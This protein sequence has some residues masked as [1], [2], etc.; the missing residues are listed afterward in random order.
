[1]QMFQFQVKGKEQGITVLVSVS[2]DISDPIH[3]L[4]M[5]RLQGFI[6]YKNYPHFFNQVPFPH[7]NVKPTNLTRMDGRLLTPCKIWRVAD[8]GNGTPLFLVRV[9]LSKEEETSL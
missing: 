2:R 7:K 3:F 9:F 6:S 5:A 4:L 8:I 1:M